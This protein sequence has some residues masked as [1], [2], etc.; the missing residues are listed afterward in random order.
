MSIKRR[1]IRITAA[2]VLTA[3]GALALGAEQLSAL[4]D[5]LEGMVQKETLDERVD[6]EAEEAE[7]AARA[8]G[9]GY[10]LGR[11]DGEGNP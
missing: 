2:G 3:A 4:A 6:A 5:H 11:P 7:D 10:P 1:A 8:E 9:E